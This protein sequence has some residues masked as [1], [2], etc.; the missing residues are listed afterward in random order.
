MVTLIG[1]LTPVMVYAELLE[2]AS[3][4]STEPDDLQAGA[5]NLWDIELLEKINIPQ[6]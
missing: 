1:F 6:V 3:E 2:N 5:K 4:N